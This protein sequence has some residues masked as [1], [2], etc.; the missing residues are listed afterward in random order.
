MSDKLIPV[1]IM[2]KRYLVPT[3][4]T[5]MR[6][7]EYAGYKMIRGAGCR[8]G[9]CGA[10]ATV[11]RMPDD[12]KLCVA[13]ACQTVVREGMRLAQ[14]PSFPANKALYDFATLEPDAL[15][16]LGV[17]P[18]LALCKGCNTCTK[19]C[20]QELEVMDYIAAALRGDIATAAD[21]SF[22]CIACGL[23]TARC[24]GELTPHNIALLARRL[25][26]AY[27][28]PRSEHLAKRAQEIREGKYEASVQ[29]LKTLPTDD[30]KMLY[31]TREIEK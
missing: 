21:K 14:I 16:L 13:L 30:L 28:A 26:G 3:S 7:F 12:N 4:L 17:Y 25:Y 31:N 29:A 6:A 10:C 1:Y 5:I 27:L 11:Y 2:D 15:T 23:C 9:F 19:A 8:G 22:D 18:E 20:P 24:P